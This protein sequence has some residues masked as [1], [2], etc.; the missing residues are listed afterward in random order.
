MI[1]DFW[2]LSREVTL[3]NLTAQRVI[4][5]RVA[6]LAGGGAVAHR[7]AKRM[8]AEKIAAS[9]EATAAIMSGKSPHSVVRRY[10]SIVGANERRLLRKRRH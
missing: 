10:R 3:A 1:F 2:K 6:R 9:A 4:A 8:I 5:L 7:E